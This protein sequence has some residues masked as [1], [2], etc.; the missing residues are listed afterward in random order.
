MPGNISPNALPRDFQGITS[1]LMDKLAQEGVLESWAADANVTGQDPGLAVRFEIVYSG[2]IG[3]DGVAVDAEA[4][5]EG[6]GQ[7]AVPP[8]VLNLLIQRAR[9]GDDS[10]LNI[11]EKW[12][13]DRATYNATH[14]PTPE[15]TSTAE[16]EPV[17]GGDPTE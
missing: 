9:E 2:I 11:L 17:P 6:E 4:R 5:G 7:L 8:E 15:G 16:P 1:V 10:A 3:F 14:K 12:L 13:S